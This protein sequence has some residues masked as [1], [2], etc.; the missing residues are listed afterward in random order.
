[1]Q[2]F[3]R[4]LSD[5]HN[6]LANITESIR[7]HKIRLSIIELAKGKESLDYYKMYMCILKLESKEASL[8]FLNTRKTPV[9]A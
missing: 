7:H 3:R 5:I 4:E 2:L 8:I 9:Y 6:Q 1:M